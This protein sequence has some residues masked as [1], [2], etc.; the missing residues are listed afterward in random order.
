IEGL[1]TV[2]A[3][4]EPDGR[5]STARV[6]RGLG[7]GLDENAIVALRQWRFRPGARAGA[8]VGM[9]AEFDIEFSLSHDVVNSLIANDMATLVGPGVT[10]PRA[11]RVV[12]E[13]RWRA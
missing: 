11:I 10:P 5:V 1:V 3:R 6:L 8:P 12:R 13:K 4:V 2:G 7:A 9:D